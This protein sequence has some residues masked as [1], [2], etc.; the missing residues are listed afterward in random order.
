MAQAKKKREFPLCPICGCK[1]APGSDTGKWCHE[2]C[3]AIQA[4][5]AGI[6]ASP[7]LEGSSDIVKMAI[8]VREAFVQQAKA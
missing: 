7:R 2:C 5:C 6:L 3:D 8:C 1:C 4:F